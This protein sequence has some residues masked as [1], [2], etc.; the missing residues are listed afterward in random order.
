MAILHVLTR[1]GSPHEPPQPF[2]GVKAALGDFGMLDGAKLVALSN[3][4]GSLNLDAT[5]FHRLR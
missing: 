4:L 2:D 3:A 5:G 1:G